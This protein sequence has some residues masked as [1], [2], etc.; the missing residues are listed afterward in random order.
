MYRARGLVLRVLPSGLSSY[1]RP[2]LPSVHLISDLLCAIEV[3]STYRFKGP[4][5]TSG[6]CCEAADL[7]KTA[8]TQGGARPRIIGE[9][10]VCWPHGVGEEE[11]RLAQ[12]REQFPQFID[13]L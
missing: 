11:A 13:G 6:L 10:L 3:V 2:P 4:G 8:A 9:M 7:T 5:N 1:G 12:H